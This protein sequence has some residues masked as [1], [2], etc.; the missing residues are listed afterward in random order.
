MSYERFTVTRPRPGVALVT[1]D[2]ADK[3]NAMD[4][5]F[6]RE[7]VAVTD[8][9]GRDPDVRAAVLTGGGQAFSAG[10]DIDSFHD[11][12]GDTARLRTH[13]RLVFDA[14]SSVERCTV[15]VIGAINGIAYGGA[16]S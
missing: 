4:P 16:P 6:F 3:L 9:L 2:R 10:G 11:M 5:V 8:E 15:P 7:L 13:A 1:I 12:A 14:F